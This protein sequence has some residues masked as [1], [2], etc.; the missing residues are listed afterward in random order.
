M[1]QIAVDEPLPYAL[2]RLGPLASW[3]DG[4]PF[5]RTLLALQNSS[6]LPTL[7]Q[8]QEMLDVPTAEFVQNDLINA[9]FGK[10]TFQI[11]HS[12]PEV[13]IGHNH[14][15]SYQTEPTMAEMEDAIMQNAPPRR[16]TKGFRYKR[17]PRTA[18]RPSANPLVART[19]SKSTSPWAPYPHR[20][21]PIRSLSDDGETNEA[22]DSAIPLPEHHTAA[23]RDAPIARE[24]LH[25]P[26]YLSIPGRERARATLL[27]PE[28]DSPLS[29]HSPPEG[30]ERHP[31]PPIVAKQNI[32]LPSQHSPRRESQEKSDG[33]LPVPNREGP[34]PAPLALQQF[35]SP[36][37]SHRSS[38][39]EDVDR[40]DSLD[41]GLS[42]VRR[43]YQHTN[44][45]DIVHT[46][47]TCYNQPEGNAYVSR[48][49][50]IGP[51]SL[52]RP[53]TYDEEPASSEQS[54]RLTAL[55]RLSPP[56]K[57]P[58]L[59]PTTTFTDMPLSSPET[60]T[61][62]TFWVPP[63]PQSSR[64]PLPLVARCSLF[65]SP[66]ARLKEQCTYLLRDLHLSPW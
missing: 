16:R 57:R 20:P 9:F 24:V 38:S 33:P 56:H 44:T 50:R 34:R 31:P 30:R 27:G 61:Q 53:N 46:S 55:R 7:E 41:S 1:I 28:R 23:S 5:G 4:K 32:S 29:H 54:I 63:E 22:R 49:G 15:T 59:P 3:R 35:S 19:V 25:P 47:S 17:I 42:E 21:V 2:S 18:P 14:T 64:S 10:H 6:F 65:Q 8:S 43:S 60:A 48:V 40:R 66:A 26:I 37:V 36:S 11:D 52:K 51:S 62:S 45:G 13:F 12:K 58:R 39:E